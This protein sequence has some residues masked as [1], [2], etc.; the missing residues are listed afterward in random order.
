MNIERIFST[1]E[2]I[3]ILK[4]IIFKEGG[5]GVSEV[6]EKVRVSKSL[7]STYFDVLV[8][9]GILKK[10]ASGVFVTDSHKVK[11]VKL[12][13]NMAGINVNIF[14]KYPFVSSVGLYGSCARGENT[15][16]SD[17]DLWI[18]VKEPTEAE[19]GAL[20]TALKN[21]LK[22]ANILFLTDEKIKKLKAEDELFYYSLVFGSI[23]IYGEKDGI[24]L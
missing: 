9:E 21:K 12:F 1:K 19:L 11:A 10:T 5:I 3:R 17:I 15:E 14:K 22:N 7:V 23:V 16:D 20:R 6:A 24:Q 8:K 2:R 4:E 13:L 18:R